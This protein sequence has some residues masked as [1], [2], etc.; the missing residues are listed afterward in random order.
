MPK[1]TVEARPAT[2]W[3]GR[4]VWTGAPRAARS[5]SN[6]I[7]VVLDGDV[8][9]IRL[10]R[11]IEPKGDLNGAPVTVVSDTFLDGS[12]TRSTFHDGTQH[13]VERT[14]MA[15]SPVPVRTRD[16]VDFGRLEAAVQ[17]LVYEAQRYSADNP[18]TDAQ[19]ESLL[20]SYQGILQWREKAASALAAA[21]GKIDV[22]G[23]F[24]RRVVE[25]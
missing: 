24:M 8:R 25:L 10:H 4:A 11:L 7:V 5:E 18:P 22:A 9:R 2:M 20:A 15:I 1:A 3:D 16:F 6:V 23:A 13:D 12:T 17:A 19:L 14:S 21:E